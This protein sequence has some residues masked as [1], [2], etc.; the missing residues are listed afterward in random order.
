MLH[1]E[2][3]PIQDLIHGHAWLPLATT[4]ANLRGRNLQAR[5]DASRAVTFP[6]EIFQLPLLMHFYLA[7]QFSDLMERMYSKYVM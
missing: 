2:A 1:G 3:P 6:R 5:L 4:F 7:Y